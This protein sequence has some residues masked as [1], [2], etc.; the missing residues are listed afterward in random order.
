M[1]YLFIFRKVTAVFQGWPET[2]SVSAPVTWLNSLLVHSWKVTL[3]DT[4]MIY[5]R[6]LPGFL[7]FSNH[8]ETLICLIIKDINNFSSLNLHIVL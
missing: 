1:I 8:L 3:I 7:Y 4:N 6:S 5:S 2:Q